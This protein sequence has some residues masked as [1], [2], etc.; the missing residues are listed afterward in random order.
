MFYKKSQIHAQIF[1]YVIAI[2]L[3]SLILVYGY[4]AIKGFKE[5]S[6][7]ITYIRFKTDLVST[8]ERVSPDYGTTKREEFFVGGNYDRVCFVQSY[9]IGDP[10][11]HAYVRGNINDNIILDSFESEVNKNVFLFA[12]TLQESFDIGDINVTSGYLCIPIIN[13]KARLEFEGKGDHTL[14]SYHNISNG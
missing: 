3:F 14:I 6:D 10:I 11:T 9:G 1:I 12:N 4:N 5:R 2:I 7:Q 8:V 13:G